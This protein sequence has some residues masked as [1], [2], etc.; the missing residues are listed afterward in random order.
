[1]RLRLVGARHPLL[2]MGPRR[3]ELV[4]LDLELQPPGRLLLVSGPNMGGK[5]VLLKTVGLAVALAHAAFPVPAAEGSELPEITHVWVDLGDDQSVDR[6]LSTFAGHLA[7]LSEMVAAAGPDHLLLCD[8]L[9]TGT[10]PEEGA[11][12]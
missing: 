4:P 9:G 5:T 10:D 11:A 2:A 12:L 7:R 8:E 6:G 3:D 1:P